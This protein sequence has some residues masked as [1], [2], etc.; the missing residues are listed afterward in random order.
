MSCC[1]GTD[2]PILETT[3][4]GLGGIHAHGW[5]MYAF[6]LPNVVVVLIKVVQDK[7]ACMAFLRNYKFS[8]PFLKES[9]SWKGK[10]SS[11]SVTQVHV[12]PLN[13]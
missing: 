6:A 13:C 8:V 10:L 1:R 2:S 12:P 9:P 3:T 7:V 5:Q 11:E 4:C